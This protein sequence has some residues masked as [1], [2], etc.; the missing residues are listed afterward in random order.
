MSKYSDHTTVGGQVLAHRIR[1]MKQN[2]HVIWIIGRVSFL[3]SFFFYVMFN[4]KINN[5]WNYLCIVKGS[6]RASMT[7]LPNSLFSSSYLWFKSG[8]WKELS[9]Y[10][11]ARNETFLIIKEQVTADLWFALKLSLCLGIIAMILMVLINKYFGKSLSNKKE[12]ISGYDYVD[13]KTLKKA[14]QDKSDITLADIPYPKGAESRHT[15]ITGTTGAGKTNI[16]HELLQQ[17][18]EK[19]ERAIIVDTIGT[20]VADYFRPDRDILLNPLDYR[21]KSWNFCDECAGDQVLLNQIAECIVP[22]EN[23]NEVF[24]DE[25]ARIVFVESVKKI[26]LAGKSTKHLLK[27]LERPA[28]EWQ[29]FLKDT[30]G[31]SLMD[32]D[33]EKMAISIRAT[34]INHLACFKCLKEPDTEQVSIKKWV[35][36]GE[37]FLFF[38]CT[39]EQR[40]LITPM[41]ASWLTIALRALLQITPTTKRTWIFID[42]LH[43]L[44]RLPGFE[45][46][47]AE[48]R[49]FGGCFVLGTQMI[50]QLNDIYSRE[51]TKTITGLCGTKVVMNVPEPDTAKYMSTF[52]GEKEEIAVTE[53]ISYGANTMRDGVN[54]AQQK[55]KKNIVSASDIMALGLGE[56]FI[57]FPTVS[58]VGKIKFNYH[59]GDYRQVQNN[60]QYRI[61]EFF[62][63]TEEIPLTFGEVFNKERFFTRHSELYGNYVNLKGINLSEK[64]LQYPLFIWGNETVSDNYIEVLIEQARNEKKPL[65]VFEDGNHLYSKFSKPEDILLNPFAASGYSWDFAEDFRNNPKIADYIQN[66]LLIECSDYLK[67]FRNLTLDTSNF[68]DLFCFA[69]TPEIELVLKKYVKCGNTSDIRTTL[70]KELYFLR[71]ISSAKKMFSFWD[72]NHIVWLS[73]FDNVSIHKFYRFILDTLPKTTEVLVNQADSHNITRGNTIIFNAEFNK[74]HTRFDGSLLAFGN[75]AHNAEVAK[76]FGQTSTTNISFAGQHWRNINSPAVSEEDLASEACFFK[77]RNSYDVLKF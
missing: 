49:K 33:A 35:Q 63:K 41:L 4:Y 25:A 39:P 3:L 43:N 62:S 45:T 5:I 26:L 73:C 56:A 18:I 28:S 15:I 24:W 23:R 6:Y 37:S 36:S 75:T 55:E 44:G 72:N 32:K 16:F 74:F 47:L 31:A 40:S 42:E 61:K 29:A 38:S 34:L 67:T 22:L 27:M 21:A 30:H 69:P 8:R 48:V 2:W 1:M 76:L 65:I 71:D 10:F 68:L 64:V 17:V 46:T 77:F 14:I 20:Y 11:I 54:I 9:D 58:L 60:F 13:A 50:S 70:A 53:S 57:R 59:E 66:S 7:I 52:L 51:V 19:G 12:L